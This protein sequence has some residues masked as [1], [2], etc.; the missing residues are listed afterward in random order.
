MAIAIVLILLTIGTVIFHFAS[1]WWF[2]EIASNWGVIDDT[3]NLTFWVTGIVYVL[4]NGFL[5][6]T[7]I[8]YRHRKGQQAHHDPENK[9]LEWWLI[10]IT[11]V[12]VVAML[13]P[14][15]FAWQDVVTV[16]PEASKVE[17]LG[18]QWNWSFRYP[19]DDGAMG[20]S[21]VEFVNVA[22]PF[23]IDPDDPA[24]QDDKL[25]SEPIA[26]L[27]IG[28]PVKLLLR[29]L[30]VLHNFTVPQFR[31]KMDLVPGMITYFWLTPTRTGTFD[32]LCEEL[33][34]IGHFTM[35]GKVVVDE[36]DAFREWLEAQPTFAEISARPKGDA[37]AGQASFAVCAACHGAQGEGNKDLNAPKLSG[38]HGW[39]LR[40]QLV[41]YKNGLRGTHEDDAWG[42]QMAPM[43]A[44]LADDT[45]INNVVAY[46]DTLPD[47]PVAQTISGD[48]DRGKK[49]FV[50]CQSCH[51]AQGQGIW[52]LRAPR[53][54][55]SNDWYVATQLNNCK[56]GIRGAHPQDLYGK[57]MGFMA[58][59]MRDDEA[60]NDVIAY[61]NTL[62]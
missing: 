7:V 17:V 51:G 14:G 32:I 37:L 12:G 24:G 11:T 49:I 22:N 61:L 36:Q 57:Q 18:Q 13:A 44:T 1:P 26:H 33:C 23:G 34:G 5:V 25:V 62:Q 42:Q 16:P 54:A 40:G 52:S 20:R 41:N 35:R 10:G 30:D 45:A 6:W 27:P 55:R 8:R 47:H 60:V 46:I 9:K 21:G 58:K 39:Y 3:V 48:A 43:A 50:T 4:L 28:K 56:R 19:G 15:L 29:S 38:Q 2:T 59:I 53:I 31:M